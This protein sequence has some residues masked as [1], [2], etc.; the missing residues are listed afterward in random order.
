MPIAELLQLLY[1]PQ[2]QIVNK[3]MLKYLSQIVEKIL[4]PFHLNAG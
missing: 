4:K 3:K 2:N 1:S